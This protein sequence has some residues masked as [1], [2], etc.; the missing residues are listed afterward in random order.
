MCKQL[1]FGIPVWF[2]D[3]V[4]D[5]WDSCIVYYGVVAACVTVVEWLI[6]GILV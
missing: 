6:S 3:R 1:T 4:V 2:S 5:L